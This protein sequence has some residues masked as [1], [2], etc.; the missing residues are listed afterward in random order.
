MRLGPPGAHVMTDRKATEATEAT[1]LPTV[2]FGRRQRLYR[3]PLPDMT[4]PY[5]ACIGAERTFAREVARP[6]PELAGEAINLP[7]LNLGVD[8]A[9]PGFFLADPVVLQA[10]SR[11]RLC[12]LEIGSAWNLSNRFY[13]VG[14]RYNRRLRGVSDMLRMLY[15]DVDLASFVF[16]GKLLEHLHAKDPAKFAL[17]EGECRA[18]WCA[19]MGTLLDA[20]E[21]P[22]LLLW[23][24]HR[25]PEDHVRFDP[26]RARSL[27]PD[28][29]DRAM[30]D[31]ARAHSQGYAEVILDGGGGGGRAALTQKMHAEIAAT[32]TAQAAKLLA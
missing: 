28:A 4:K 6:W 13:T 15:P 30:V 23:F 1:E 18:A 8:G 29:V 16:V 32:L 19:R 24:S 10:C 25:R 27:P 21:A 14:R 7:A 26:R 17:I 12:V 20:I 2:S 11:A 31:A 3:A 22:K 5:M 9:G